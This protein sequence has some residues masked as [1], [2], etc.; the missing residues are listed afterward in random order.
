MP[1]NTI[2]ASAFLSAIIESSDD[3]IVGKTLDG[4]ILSWNSAAE[5]LYQYS[6]EEAVGRNISLIIPPEGEGELERILKRIERGERV[7]HHE[8]VRVRKDGVRLEVSI[9]VSPIKNIEGKVIGASAITRDITERKLI[10]KERA[11]LQAEVIRTQKLLLEELSTPLIP[12]KE[13]IVVMPLIGAMNDLRAGQMLTTLLEG[14]RERCPRFAIIDITGVSTVDTQV[15]SALINAAAAVKLMGT[16]IIITG[17][18][19]RVAQTLIGLGVDL[20]GIVTRRNLKS[21]I[22]YAEGLK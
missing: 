6:A 17:M 16:E 20:T 22:D 9:T 8:T 10:E 7:E 11:S 15:A 14:I 1:L 18:R 2:E 12:I 5:R 13:G 19:G 4:T 21:G 3:A